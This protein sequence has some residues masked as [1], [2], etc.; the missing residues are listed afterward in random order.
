MNTSL[1]STVRRDL[2][3]ALMLQAAAALGIALATGWGW[4]YAAKASLAMALAL[5]LVAWG[6]ARSALAG[7]AAGLA[8]AVGSA[9]ATARTGAS[10]DLGAANRVTLLR[11]GL[12]MLLAAAVGEPLDAGPGLT[13]VLVGMATVAALLDAV[14]GPLARRTGRATA[15]GA[16][17]DM[18]SDAW[19]TLVLSVLVWQLDR[20][21]AW[22]LASGL[23]R[24]AF[25][26]ATWG[27]PWLGAPLA[28]RRRRQAVCVVQ[29]IVLIVALAPVGPAA[30]A[31]ALCAAGLLLLSASFGTDAWL[32]WRAH[33]APGPE[34]T[35]A[36]A[37][38][39]AWRR[40]A[41]WVVRFAAAAF[42]LN[43]LLTFESR[44]DGIG[45]HWSPRL[46]FELCL[47]LLMLM[48]WVAWRGVPG[49]R[50]LWA[51][52]AICA[53]FSLLR[54]VDVTVPAF[55]GR[56]VNLYWDAPHAWQLIRLAWATWPAWQVLGIAWAVVLG[57][58]AIVGASRW[59]LATLAGCLLVPPVRPWLAVG[60]ALLGA[61][62]AA[63]P[64]VSVDTRWFFSLPVA[65]TLA[66]QVQ[67]LG[68]ALSRERTEARLTPSPTF[69]GNLAALRGADVLLLF[70]ESY[71][72]ATLDRPDQA[73]ALAGPREKLAQ[74][75]QRSGL[76]VV[77]AR[78]RSPTFGGGSWL[79]HAGLLAGVDTRDPNDYDLLL[80]TKRPT[81][82]S[83]F[84]RHGWRT[85]GWMPGMQRPWPEVSFYGFE[86]YADAQGVGYTGPGFG[87][88][89]IPDQASIA[90]L[91]AQE[92]G[93]TAM[94]G[95]PRKPRFVV[96]PT[97]ETHAPFHP[98]APYQRQWAQL[99]TRSAYTPEQLAQALAPTSPP[100]GWA[101][102]YVSAV[103]HTFEWLGDYLAERAPAHL[104]TIVIGD[105]Q[106]LAAV[107]GAGASWAVP[108]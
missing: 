89:R 87:Y 50:A 63:H 35:M 13:W 76:Q 48:A 39:G 75:L 1:P 66:R 29:I 36:P 57:V 11:L 85:V 16:R 99:L 28:P 72:A 15:F 5:A 49:R 8:G 83:H 65:P 41:G 86:R 59:A 98:I 7:G 24:Y 31:G 4:A 102:A 78:V 37:Q 61:S 82:V 25:V 103:K 74:A 45:V 79:A 62:F 42:V 101:P 90:L 60:G 84:A 23:M 91:H 10:S 20:A 14:D 56:P 94:P 55:F 22:V 46:S 9:P 80:T 44:M 26:A 40:A 105:H 81:L 68:Q 96:F 64:F 6:F 43:T 71:G 12:A 92:L 17:F 38:A 108:V 88:W 107:S 70:A 95:Q 33:A 3:L 32:L 21:G 54:Y 18:E 2:C 52:A 53:A 19:L 67:L 77:S 73:E 106:P 27:W 58:A 69:Q 93:A 51:L 30:M 97:L 104:R 47:G 34:R 100:G